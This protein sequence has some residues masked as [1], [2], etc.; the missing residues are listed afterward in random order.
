M[1]RP[2]IR[3]IIFLAVFMSFGCM[4]S[5]Q[6][7]S[8]GTS[9]SD[10]IV[11]SLIG[12]QLLVTAP[13]NYAGRLAKLIEQKGGKAIAAPSIH[14]SLNPYTRE[15]KNVL[16]HP[17][18]Y[19]WVVLP[20]RKA[21]DAFFAV[22]SDKQF[23]GSLHLFKICAI[24]K[25][26]EYLKSS[27]HMEAAL[28]PE[29]A[30]PAGIIKVL[31]LMPDVKG[32]SIV[33]IA[34]KVVGLREPDVIPDFI[35]G[36]KDIGMNPVKIEGYITSPQNAVNYKKEVDLL[37]NG[38]IDLLIFSSATEAEALLSI[39]GDL[40]L[41]NKQKIACFG[42]Y[43][44]ANVEKLGIRVDYVGKNY[45]SFDAFVDEICIFIK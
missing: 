22:A 16:L 20:S 44:A 26:A 1:K 11:C 33:V 27:Y 23:A 12:K 3:I 34:P 30:S 21:I 10:T 13:E 15:I 32:Q 8:T 35:A 2:V 6:T 24:G 14:T 4:T 9:V 40:E 39:V 28:V 18:V 17:S 42:P 41:L 45:H 25:D 36:L 31:A 37:Y 29:E 19:S 7:L 43:T 5:A 38:K